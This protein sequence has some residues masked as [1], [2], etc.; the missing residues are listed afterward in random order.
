MSRPLTG[1]IVENACGTFAASVPRT[2]GSAK[3]K[4]ATFTSRSA[5]ERWVRACVVALETGRPLPEP[6]SGRSSTAS[7]PVPVG[8]AFKPI[9]EDFVRERYVEDGHGDIGREEQVRGYIAVIDEYMRWKRLTLENITRKDARKMFR[10]LLK[11]GEAA[12]VGLPKALSPETQ[13]TKKQAHALLE[14]HGHPVSDSTFKRA[15]RCGAL[16]SVDTAGRAHLYRLDHLFGPVAGLVSDRLVSGGS[17]GPSR[18]GRYSHSTL[19]EVRRTFIAV[20]DYAKS[21]GITL[22]PKVR[23]AQLPKDKTPKTKTRALTLAETAVIAGRLHVVHQLVLWLLRTLG[24]RISEAYGLLVEDVIDLGPGKAGLLTVQSQGGKKFH[25][26]KADGSIRVT[27]RVEGTKCDSF[28]VL[29]VP[30]AVMAMIGVV[31]DAFHT[32][33]DGV[34]RTEARLVPGLREADKGGQSAFR[35][36]LKFAA[37]AEGLDVVFDKRRSSGTSGL[38]PVVPTPQHMRRSFATA[39]QAS[40]EAIENIRSVMGH[41]RGTEVI[42]EHYLLEDPELKPQRA[43]AESLSAQIIA[44]IP[45]GLLVPTAQSCTTRRQPE[46]AR[47]KAEI[48]CALIE[49]GWLVVVTALG[50]GG[51]SVEDVAALQGVEPVYVRELIKA[52]KLQATKVTRTDQ[53]GF[54][55]SITVADALTSRDERSG[56]HAMR[57]LAAELDRPYD[58]VRQYIRRHPDLECEPFGDRDYHVPEDVAAHVAAYFRRQDALELRAVRMP[59]VAGELGVS[60]AAV[61][62]LIK[63]GV[64]VE[65]DRFHGGVRSITVVSLEAH[66]RAGRGR[67]RRKR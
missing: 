59:V 52:G 35:Q 2:S 30:C 43:I 60:V 55:Y 47:R 26:R 61:N 18:G 46:L 29:V 62:T 51:L 19:S 32:D 39:L 65:D 5:A 22:Q 56:R 1:S 42:H 15:V 28:R 20:L 63:H 40:K 25:R 13:V 67:G 3:R 36:A 41:R 8:T 21:E 34:V 31:I 17:D 50:D 4:R 48:D 49:A 14:A 27:D 54:R 33:Q 24:L 66:R 7:A 37:A 44:E 53:G 23:T 12:T 58:T 6:G 9:G 16:T 45:D 38:E 10:H 57:E 64:L 11:T